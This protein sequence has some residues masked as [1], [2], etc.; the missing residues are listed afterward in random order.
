MTTIAQ[1]GLRVVRSLNRFKSDQS[2]SYA[3]L[4]AL[5]LTPFIL[6][7]GA[8]VDYSFANKAKAK[9]S[10]LA[11]S[12]ALTAV[13]H[14]AMSSNVT[15][16]QTAAQ[17][18]FSAQAAGINNI[19]LTDVS[20][21]VTDS[22]LNRTAVVSYSATKRTLFMGM[23]GISAVTL[24]GQSTA[25]SAQSTY[26]DFYLLL[27]NTP[28]M[29]VGATTNDIQTMVNNTPDQCAFACHDL[30]NSNSYYNLAK[31]LGVTMRIDTVR[32][33]TQQLMDT[34]ASSATYQGQ[35]R[36]AI[37]TFGGSSA[38]A[39]LTTISPLTAD[40]S[41]AKAAAAAIDLMT[42]NG[43]NQFNDQDTNFDAIFPSMDS[44]IP[45]PGAG[46]SDAPMKVLFFVSDGVADESNAQSCQQKLSGQTRCQEPLNVALCTAIKN[47]GVKIAVL[48]TT[49]LPLPTNSWYNTWIKPFSNQISTNM[50]N[51]ASP[52]LYFEVS[53][54]QGISSAMQALFQTA[55][56]TARLIQ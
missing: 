10:S 36:M 17:N 49:Y 2:G 16:A 35:Y 20:V 23:A 6:V 43:Q 24:S 52:G 14:M 46:T 53:P 13:N 8:A 26:I 1:A 28:S 37:Y 29:G 33:A 4:F 54:T 21:N 55:V 18:M 15:A 47:R 44:A 19:T 30:S 5:S 42:V 34:A 12:A 32:S 45:A 48:Y 41:S 22:A 40:L 7:A 38:S 11:D 9:L 25:V 51:C 3:T 50:Q 56:T 39:G 31:K 27:D